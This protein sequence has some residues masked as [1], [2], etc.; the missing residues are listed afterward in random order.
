MLSNG[1][2]SDV[3]TGKQFPV[4]MVESGPAGG[5]ILAGKISKECK[6]DKVV[7]FDMGGDEH[8][9]A[10]VEDLSKPYSW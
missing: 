3:E 5:A 8:C 6:L 1:G 10:Y 2:L 7:S 9:E 4:R